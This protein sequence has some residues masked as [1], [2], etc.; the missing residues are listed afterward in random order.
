MHI[1]QKQFDKEIKN[2]IANAVREDVGEGDH[3]SLACIPETATGTAKLLVKEE[4]VLAGVEFARRVFD[5]I[6]TELRLK[7]V[8]E[9][10]E[11]MVPGDIVFEVSGKSRSILKAE[12]LM[13][14]GMQRMSAIATK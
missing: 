3:S 4:G 10:G 13:L 14:N 11:K 8:K 12:R 1:D 2:I 6:D 9:E 7:I 5:Y